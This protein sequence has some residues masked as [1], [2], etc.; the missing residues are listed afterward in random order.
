LNNL[1]ILISKFLDKK[2][3]NDN[4]RYNENDSY[5]FDNLIDSKNISNKK[6]Y[7][8]NNNQ[9]DKNEM[10]SKNQNP[11]NKSNK[12]LSPKFLTSNLNLQP[13]ILV[14]AYIAIV[15]LE[16]IIKN[17][18]YSDNLIYL[19]ISNLLIISKSNSES[20]KHIIK[21]F[22][23]SYFLNYLRD[24]LNK[25]TQDKELFEILKCLKKINFFDFLKETCE[26]FFNISNYFLS[27]QSKFPTIELEDMIKK[28]KPIYEKEDAEYVYIENISSEFQK[29]KNN[30]T[31]S[32]SKKEPK[33]DLKAALKRGYIFINNE[34]IPI[35]YQ[36]TPIEIS[37]EELFQ[38]Y[39]KEIQMHRENGSYDSWERYL[40]TMFYLTREDCYRSLRK[41]IEII[42]NRQ[43]NDANNKIKKL[44]DVYFYK[45]IT[46]NSIE[47]NK[48]GLTIKIL[49]DLKINNI[50]ILGNKRLLNGSLVILTDEK[51]E[52]IVFCLVK[53]IDKDYIKKNKT[54]ALVSLEFLNPK[55]DD[56]KKMTSLNNTNFQM[57]ESKAFYQAYCHILKRLKS[58]IPRHL[59]FTNIIINFI[60]DHYYSSRMEYVPDYCKGSMVYNKTNFMP[61]K[62]TWPSYF[63]NNLD[64]SQF[65]SIQY[66][67]LNKVALIQGPP[68]TGKTFV[69]TLICKIIME[70]TN[71]PI[72]IVCYT[73]HALDQFLGHIFKYEKNILRIGGRC[74][75]EELN[76][77]TLAKKRFESFEKNKMNSNKRTLFSVKRQI[78]QITESL[79]QNLDVINRYKGINY[80]EMQ[81]NF[82]NL[83]DK[84]FSDFLKLFPKKTRF[85]NQGEKINFTKV[86]QKFRKQLLYSWM[87]LGNFYQLLGDISFSL[88]L[89]DEEQDSLYK[90]H[91]LIEKDCDNKK[92]STK[93]VNTILNENNNDYEEISLEEDEEEN[94]NRV[95]FNQGYNDY[96]NENI[97]IG[98]NEPEI[99]NLIY[100]E[101]FIDF[102]DNFE[103][104]RLDYNYFNY[105]LM[106]SPNIWFIG[107]NVRYRM[108]F[109]IKRNI[110]GSVEDFSAELEKL[111]DLM[112]IKNEL[113]N[114]QDLEIIK[115][116]KIVGMTTTGCAKYS[117]Y[118][119]NIDFKTVIVEE[120]AEVVESHMVSLLTKKTQHL[121]MIGDHFQLRPKIYNFEIEKKYKFD[122]SLFERLINNKY[123]VKSLSHQRRMRPEF[124]DFVR[125]IYGNNYNDHEITYTRESIKGFYVDKQINKNMIFF[126]HKNMEA[127]NNGLASKENLFEAEFICYWARF[128]IQQNIPEEKITILSFY[129][130]QIL[131]IKEQLK[132]LRIFNIR[133]SSVD[134]Y[135]G[136][137]ND[138]ILLSLVRSNNEDNIGFLKVRN[139]VCVAFSRVKLGFFVLGNFDFL[140]KAS[141]VEKNKKQNEVKSLWE[142]IYDLAK[143]KN[144]LVDE[145]QISCQK[146][147]NI[148]LIKTAK[149]FNNIPEGGCKQICKERMECGHICE[150]FCH[151]YSHDTVQ[152]KKP[153]EKIIPDC[154]HKCLRRCFEQCRDCL[155]K[156]SKTYDC[157]HIVMTEC[158][159][160]IN[161]LKCFEKCEKILPCKH[162]CNGICSQ[163]CKP[164][165]CTE[166]TLKILLCGHKVKIPCN[167]PIQLFECDVKCDAILNLSLLVF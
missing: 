13:E 107:K 79:Q 16:D 58:L 66:S 88:N 135:Q 38:P 142:E 144:I 129:V 33:I 62:N 154:K 29:Y 77:L 46:L 50:R 160:K 166:L 87:N 59:P 21:T 44:S 159:K 10:T 51:F 112:K 22:I 157:G 161:N 12:F 48:F 7:D 39:I 67:L 167:M 103:R 92:N 6:K 108:I 45:T 17:T 95:I 119:E 11:V 56:I 146:H 140:Q 114:E 63:I 31:S 165:E 93:I 41:E 32:S 54:R 153:C 126:N 27:F 156:V 145:L 102:Q 64:K 162:K 132:Y 109:I 57:F 55:F 76:N 28:L 105:E 37:S 26:F 73:N 150:L 9:N 123:P 53:E 91:D 163:P 96:E 120:A 139:R 116:H 24:F 35:D 152:C 89:D 122:I 43:P 42:S 68:G 74:K 94:M 52:N 8:F 117:A 143:F 155:T 121:I 136:E 69:G 99:Q 131:R 111:A 36:E 164:D 15:D 75:N 49:I 130:G 84:I 61:L 147:K 98:D 23:N 1:Y 101:A 40:N 25:K 158:Y 4:R 134:N 141:K 133:V 113:E 149:D 71:T 151:N 104:T 118:L 14:Q 72:L 128:L 97:F 86:L 3:K 100:D 18:N 115:S 83:V 78:L 124:A 148:T 85:N 20:A 2:S 106:N 70:S 110:W 81:K 30:L 82:P 65:E 138:Y 125:L 90:L 137:E 60:Q 47:A 19:Q 34:N 5:Y 127:S 80:G